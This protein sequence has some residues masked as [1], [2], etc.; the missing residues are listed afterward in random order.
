MTTFAWGDSRRYNSYANYFR[1]HFGQRVQKLSVNAGFTCPN[2]DGSKGT[3]GCIFCDNGAFNPSYC[4]PQKSITQQLDEG[5]EFHQWRYRKSIDYLAYFQ[6]FS[7]TYKPLQELK[8]LYGEALAHPK[9]IGLVIGTRPDCVDTAKLDYLKEL[10]AS[11]YIAV[12]YGIESCYNSTLQYINRCHDF[13]TTR[14]AIE[15]TASRGLHV[16]GHLIL[17]LPGETK[18]MMLHEAELLSQLPLNSLKLHQLQILKGTAM[19]N[20]Y[21]QNPRLYPAWELGEYVD[22][23]VDFLERLRPD[24]VV[25]RF[26]GEVPPRFQATPERSWRD[27]Q[28]RLIRNETIPLMVE[29]R[30]EE[31]DTWQGKNAMVSDRIGEMS[32]AQIG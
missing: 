4:N 24:I 2:R 15:T 13:E 1:L 3:G 7:N 32:G 8:M 28:D 16:G 31:R 17:G 29:K 21:S 10:S 22:F 25:E 18:E 9:V 11:H 27:A 30:M 12:E 19:E 6:A 14:S 20:D 5:I 23:V 26:A